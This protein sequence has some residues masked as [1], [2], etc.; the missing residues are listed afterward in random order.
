M[1]APLVS[2]VITVFN[3]EKTAGEAV[4]S[5]LSQT[6]RDFEVIVVDDGS[7]DSTRRLIETKYAGEIRYLYQPNR[8]SAAARNAGARA[9]RGRYLA[10]L[11]GDD[12]SLPERLAL[13]VAALEQN[14]EVGLVYGNVYLVDASGGH[15]RLRGGAGRYK[16]GRV[17]EDLV[18]R[19][20]VPFSTIMLRHSTLES[21][22]LFDESIRSSEDWDMLVRLSKTCA[23]LYLPCPLVKYRIMPNSKTANIEE[24]ERAYRRV[25]AKI[26]A[27][28]DFGS[29][30]SHLRRLSEAAIYFG[31]LGISLRYGKYGKAL[32]YAIK[33][34]LATPLIVVHMRHEIL[35]RILTP[36][37]GRRRP[38]GPNRAAS[39]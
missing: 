5:F 30:I 31:L 2:A 4:E 1:Q 8:G 16:S 26:F 34:L 25:Q 38:A 19:N 7:T 17:F 9:A 18:I 21:V 11:D 33:G 14:P 24:K 37:T 28:N 29:R 3:N 10:F 32:R 12:V 23:F 20:F 22:G 36:L 35:S 27:E 39:S 13:Q 15:A 6:F